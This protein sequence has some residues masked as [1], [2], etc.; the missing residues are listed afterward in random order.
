ML[1]EKKFILKTNIFRLMELSDE[2]F[3]T[4]KAKI[5]WL[6]LALGLISP[7][8]T[9]TY[10]LEIFEEILSLLLRNK[11]PTTQDIISRVMERFRSEKTA[12]SEKL[13]HYHLK[14]LLDYGLVVRK[15]RRY[16]LNKPMG[17]MKTSLSETLNFVIT[18]DLEKIKS[19]ITKIADSLEKDFRK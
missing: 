1:P 9:R 18:Q 17:S 12:P 7:N 10:F 2:T 8:E 3:L 4:K 6:A 16:Y 11:E 19:Q 5:R 14:R 15:N 13:V